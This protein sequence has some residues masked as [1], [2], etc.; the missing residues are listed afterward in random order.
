VRTNEQGFT[1]VSVLM[2]VVILTIGILALGKT[3]AMVVR[4]SNRA[5]TS[6]QAVSLARAYME[7]VRSR[8]PANLVSEKLAYIDDEGQPDAAGPYTR[9]LIVTDLASNLKSVQVVV[10]MPGSS[11]PVELITMAFVGSL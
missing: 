2:A 9:Q 6:T 5:A 10:T 3:S 8:T 1:L 4:S 11:V 7:E